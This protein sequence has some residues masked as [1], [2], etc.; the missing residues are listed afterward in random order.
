MQEGLNIKALM[1]TKHMHPQQH[2]SALHNP[3]ESSD[4]LRARLQDTCTTLLTLNI[5]A[6]RHFLT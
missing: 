2:M 5:Q 1:N 4:T 6:V 3:C